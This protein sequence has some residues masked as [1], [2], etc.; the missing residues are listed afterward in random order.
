MSPAAGCRIFQYAMMT[1]SGSF[2]NLIPFIPS[3]YK[4]ADKHGIWHAKRR[5]TMNKTLIIPILCIFTLV[6]WLFPAGSQADTMV[7]PRV[8]MDEAP[9]PYQDK[10]IVTDTE[11]TKL[12]LFNEKEWSLDL[13]GLYAFEAS[14]GAYD[15][16][17]GPGIGLN[18]FFNRYIGVG[19]EGYTWNG[20]GYIGSASGNLI[21]R[22]PIEDW[23]LAPYLIAGVGGNF[24]AEDGEDQ[25]NGSGGIGVEYRFNQNWSVFTDARYVGTAKTNDY[26]IAR[27]GIRFSF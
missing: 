3:A 16:G 12:Y 4:S 20:D 21:L 13:F 27:T 2:L 6:L 19:L 15:D 10:S 18:Y 7:K 23:H 14:N 17:F 26:G 1:I 8:S 24:G 22:Y 25:I 5:I 9:S 11:Q